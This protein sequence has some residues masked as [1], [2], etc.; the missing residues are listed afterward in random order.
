MA[1]KMTRSEAGRLGGLAR[2]RQ[3]GFA[4]HNRRIAALGGRALFEQR[5]ARYMAQ[6]GMKGAKATISA[7]G[8]DAFLDKIRDYRLKHPSSLEAEMAATLDDLGLAYEREYVVQP[9]TGRALL[10]DFYL[11]GHNLVIEV[12]GRVHDPDLGF[13]DPDKERLREERIR[14][15]GYRLLV[16]GHQEMTRAAEMILVEIG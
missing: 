13:K 4:D 15:A 2:A 10:V 6:I 7:H 12:N 3:P 9:P 5:G 16:I 11:P 14:E 1:G 8:Y